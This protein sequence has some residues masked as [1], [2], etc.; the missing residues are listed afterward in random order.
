M[1]IHLPVVPG[2]Y[3]G[4]W[5]RTRYAEPASPPHHRADTTTRVAW[6]QGKQWHADLRLPTNGP[7]FT[8]ITCLEACDRHQLE[9]L[10]SL[11]AFAGITQI[12][13]SVCTWHRFQDL[14]PSLERDVGQ[15]I[16]MDDNIIEE[17]HPTGCYVEHW[18]RLT[19]QPAREVIHTDEQGQLRWLEI[20]DHAIA[21]T[22]RPLAANT[23]NLF[24]PLADAADDTLRW[25]AS[26]RF[27]YMQRSH[28]GWN[29]LLSTHPWRVG[30]R[31]T[32]VNEHKIYSEIPPN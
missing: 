21:I 26:L 11:T 30:R 29:I 16:W 10:A 19:R 13:G 24:L 12:E 5:Q 25:R 6:L 31:V 8:G 7:D 1:S 23:E 28:D 9:W 2:R 17:R 15:L 27:D 14:C 20:G 3:Q 22:P 32:V 4:A 18:Q